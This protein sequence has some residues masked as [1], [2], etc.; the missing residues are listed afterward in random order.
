MAKEYTLF[1]RGIPPRATKENSKIIS[2]MVK[3]N[4]FVMMEKFTKENSKMISETEKA[5]KSVLMEQYGINPI[6]KDAA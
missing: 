4:S 6:P 1:M 5:K 3:G 2:F